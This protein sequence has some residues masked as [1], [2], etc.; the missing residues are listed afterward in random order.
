M[1]YKFQLGTT[2]LSGSTTF[3][4]DLTS[5]GQVEGNTL[6]SK[7]IV[8]GSGDGRFLALDIDGT[9]VI[10]TARELAN[11]ASL[12]A[13]TEATIESAIDTLNNLTSAGLSGNDLT[14]AGP[15][16][17]E[18]GL[19][20]NG[21]IIL[22]DAGALSELTTISGSGQLTVGSIATDG[23]LTAGSLSGSG[24][25]QAGGAVTLDGV[26]EETGFLTGSDSLYFRDDSASGQMRSVPA[27]NF[28]G[29]IAGRGLGDANAQLEVSVSGAVVIDADA[30]SITGSI[31]GNGL[32]FAGG[33]KS[34]SSLAV[35][36]ATDGGL[37]SGAGAGGDQLALS[38]A[39][40]ATA[41]VDVANDDI[42]FMDDSDAND[43]T[44][45]LSIVDFVA[46]IAGSGLQASA[47]QLSADGA[48]VTTA[49]SG[50]TLATGVNYFANISALAGV[51]MPA[52][53]DSTVGDRV[54]VK[55]ADGVSAT[56]YIEIK[57]AASAQKID[58]TD[59][60]RL[61][62]PYAAV[63]LVYV[64]ADEWRLI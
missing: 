6:V 1:A 36:I 39:A 35:D 18:E 19:K 57:T 21:T 25:L 53:G 33:A 42:A 30:V 52:S 32:S 26:A 48:A 7:G 5:Q 20:Q 31:A 64:V 13:G 9:E 61:E 45:R 50:S 14:I 40:L 41:S 44:R 29:A 47:G 63:T 55:A 46:G 51:T 54:T 4:E 59:E 49:A 28:V 58:G 8:S 62:S 60:I 38:F 16:D 10:T 24:A 3:E 22:S 43:Q 27:T 56:N 17:I 34:I 2:T 37:D 12:D 23:A 15:L 11:I